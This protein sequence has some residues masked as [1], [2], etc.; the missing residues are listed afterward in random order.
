[1]RRKLRA[2]PRCSGISQ[3]T[4]DVLYP[5]SLAQDQLKNSW[6]LPLMLL[7]LLLLMLIR[8]LDSKE[9]E[10]EQEEDSRSDIAFFAVL[11]DVEPLSLDLRGD[12]QTDRASHD[13]TDDR[14]S[15]H[16]QHDRYDNC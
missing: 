1:M 4:A 13:C 15:H 11:I 6:V 2:Q 12:A 7:L 3:A 16:S 8:Q 10:H 5:G 14:A 9:Q